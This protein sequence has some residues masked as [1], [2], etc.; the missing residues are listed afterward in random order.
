M[1]EPIYVCPFCGK[2]VET[3][4]VP[5]YPTGK[6]GAAFHCRTHGL[7]MLWQLWTEAAWPKRAAFLAAKAGKLD[8]IV[9][10]ER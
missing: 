3:A 2:H 8:V 6:P 4:N 1:S 10:G 9:P 5:M 7:L